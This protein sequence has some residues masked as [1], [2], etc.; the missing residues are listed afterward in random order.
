MQRKPT[1]Q[2]QWSEI[3]PRPRKTI[4]RQPNTGDVIQTAIRLFGDDW[5]ADDDTEDGCVCLV[6]DDDCG[7]VVRLVLIGGWGA[8]ATVYRNEVRVG[9]VQ[10]GVLHAVAPEAKRIAG[11]VE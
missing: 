4:A 5:T 6:L 7:S 3:N 1:Q 10:P 8:K 9:F 11:Y 2:Q